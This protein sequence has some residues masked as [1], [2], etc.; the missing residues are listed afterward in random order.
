MDSVP[1]AVEAQ[2]IELEDPV[3]IGELSLIFNIKVSYYKAIFSTW[4][5]IHTENSKGFCFIFRKLDTASMRSGASLGSQYKSKK[6]AGDMKKKGK[7]D[8]YAYIPLQRSSL[9]KR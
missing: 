5:N 6:A 3:S 7:V 8:P 9:N 1:A 4:K 2:N